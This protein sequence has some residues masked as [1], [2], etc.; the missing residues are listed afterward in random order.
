[1]FSNS[2]IITYFVTRTSIDSLPANDLKA[3]NNSAQYLFKCSHVQYIKVANENNLYIRAKCIPE[4]K[5]NLIY[6]INLLNKETLDIAQTECGCPA[7]KG[8][9]ASYK[10]IAALCY[11]LEEFSRFGKLPDFLTSMAAT[12]E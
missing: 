6:K 3:I 8:P 10:H 2:Q 7:G 11:A 5:K 4:M 12:L 1:M 9:H